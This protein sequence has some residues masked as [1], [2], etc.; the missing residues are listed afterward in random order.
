LK[1]EIFGSDY[2]S[3]GHSSS[4]YSSFASAD[5]LHVVNPTVPDPEITELVLSQAQEDSENSGEEMI[6]DQ[7]VRDRAQAF[8]A[9]MDENGGWHGVSMVR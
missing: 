3:L 5:E 9:A 7:R 8:E 4:H 6:S 2:S 1:R